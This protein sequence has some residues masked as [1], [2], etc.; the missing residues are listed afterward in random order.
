MIRKRTAK[1]L[2]MAGQALL[3]GVLLCFLALLVIPRVS[4][5]DILIVRGGSMAPTVNRGAIAIVDTRARTPHVGDIV[6]FHEPPRVLVTHRVVALRDGGFITRGDA[7]KTDDPLV[8]QPA[9]VVGTVDLSVPHLGYV[10]YV[11][12]R[13]LVFVLLL[14]ATGGY[15]VLGELAVIWRELRKFRG[16]RDEVSGD[17]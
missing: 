8:R 11:L 16:P 13:P 2:W 6:S 10:L 9:D 17:A 14:G 7:N 4:P 1:W 5:F 15:L 12:E 3:W